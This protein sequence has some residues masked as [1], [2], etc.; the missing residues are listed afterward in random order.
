LEPLKVPQKEENW[1][2]TGKRWIEVGIN[3]EIERQGK[4]KSQT[5][6]TEK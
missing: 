5:I 3:K 2:Q 1:K 6:K 4:R